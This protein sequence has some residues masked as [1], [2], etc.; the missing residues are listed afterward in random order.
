MRQIENDIVGE[1]IGQDDVREN[2]PAG[3]DFFLSLMLH[4]RTVHQPKMNLDH[5]SMIPQFRKAL[6]YLDHDESVS[7]VASDNKLFIQV[8]DRDWNKILKGDVHLLRH[9]LRLKKE[10]LNRFPDRYFLR[11]MDCY[12]TAV[13]IQKELMF[14]PDSPKNCDGGTDDS[15]S[16]SSSSVNQVTNVLLS[17]YL[18]LT[19]FFL[20]PNQCLNA[21]TGLKELKRRGGNL[22]CK[23]LHDTAVAQF[24]NQL[25]QMIDDIDT[26]LNQQI[27]TIEEPA[28]KGI[29]S[30]Y[31]L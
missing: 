16:S 22:D 3:K 27:A 5:K 23:Q 7:F 8:F 28:P 11:W 24:G 1:V 30:T 17:R 31:I 10:Y 26:A 4:L 25:S 19:T 12:R 14:H 13:Q 2:R 18:V 21:W 15:S 9:I 29:Y 6:Y 20:A